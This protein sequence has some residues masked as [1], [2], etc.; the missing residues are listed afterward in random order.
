MLKSITRKR[1]SVH[2]DLAQM[3]NKALRDASIIDRDIEAPRS[4]LTSKTGND[5]ASDQIRGGSSNRSQTSPMPP[6]SQLK[7]T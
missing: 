6:D 3:A 7:T 4:E 1:R 2:G 5:A